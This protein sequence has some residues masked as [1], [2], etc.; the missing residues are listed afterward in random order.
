MIMARA[1][2]HPLGAWPE[3]MRA[4]TAAGFADEPSVEAFLRKVEQGVYPPPTRQP[5][6]LPK[7]HRGRLA[8]AIAQRHGMRTDTA[9]PPES[10]EDLI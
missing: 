9:P 7:W 5:G 6:C 10:A 4:E 1:T 8:D 3:E 2:K